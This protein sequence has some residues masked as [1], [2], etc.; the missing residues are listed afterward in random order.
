[1]KDYLTNI[2][3]LFSQYK[4]LGEK[5]FM[6]LS[7]AQL[8][9]K[10]CEECNSIGLIVKHLH[11]NMISRWTNFLTEDGEKEWRHRDNE[12]EKDFNNRGELMKKWEEGWSCLFST[13][14]NLNADDLE[15]IVYIRKQP[16]SVGEAINR[17]LTH[18]AY[19]VG[20]IVLLGKM[21][22]GE[23]WRSLSIPKGGSG[24]YNNKLEI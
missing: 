1:M 3:A 19:H 23:G 13:I 21:Q 20:Q 9:M 5:T 16:L 4:E 7:E 2:R 12:F 11:G 6:Q 24:E 22:L 18:Y 10:P 8:F 17:Q 14:D 15:K